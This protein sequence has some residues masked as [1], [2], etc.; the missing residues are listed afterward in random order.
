M[1]YCA[2]GEAPQPTYTTRTCYVQMPTPN[3]GFLVPEFNVWSPGDRVDDQVH[4]VNYPGG[5]TTSETAGF[6]HV[7]IKFDDRD[8]TDINPRPRYTVG[9]RNPPVRDQEIWFEDTFPGSAL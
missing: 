5:G 6:N 3:D 4:N 8:H 1:T 2:P 9:Q 7:E